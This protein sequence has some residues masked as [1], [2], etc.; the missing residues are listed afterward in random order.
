MFKKIIS[1]IL[2]LV[3]V[4][5]VIII[6]VKSFDGKQYAWISL[7][8][9]VVA[10]IPFFLSFEN[11]KSGT[12]EMIIISVMS[13]LG[14]VGRMAFTALPGFKPVTAIVILT[15]IYFGS[16]AGFITGA[17]T[18]VISNFY[19]GQGPWTPFQ[20]FA[21]GMTGLIAGIFA[22]HLKK[23]LIIEAIYGAFCGVLFSLLMDVW[24]AMWIDGTFNWARYLVAILTSAG[25]TALYAGSNAIFIL[26][27]GKPVG[28]ILE[29]VKLKYGIK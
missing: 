7:C 8:I 24:T 4:P 28:L 21:W 18:A 3:A 26:I 2:L 17:L 22:K 29:R 1:Y 10:C 14:V 19:F 9:C 13:A 27:L 25:F 12:R 5:V 11:S 16:E 6:G 20:M 15:A 23:S